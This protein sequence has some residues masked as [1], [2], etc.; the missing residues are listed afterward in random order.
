MMF[1]QEAIKKRIPFLK[2]QKYGQKQNSSQNV[3]EIQN[4]Q[5]QYQNQ[6]NSSKKE[7]K[8]QPFEKAKQQ[9]EKFK[10]RLQKEKDLNSQIQQIVNQQKQKLEND[11]IYQQYIE[12]ETEKDNR[13]HKT[14]EFAPSLITV[15][16]Q[17]MLEKNFLD[18]KKLNSIYRPCYQN[19]SLFACLTSI[20]NYFFT[21]LGPNNEQFDV[22][23]EDEI[24]QFF[25]ITE[26]QLSSSKN[27]IQL[28]ETEIIKKFEEFCQKKTQKNILK[29]QVLWK[30]R[31]ENQKLEKSVE[32]RKTI[33]KTLQN[34][35]NQFI[36]T[37]ISGIYMLI[38]G[39]VITPHR[40][41]DVYKSLEQINEN[42]TYFSVIL[43]DCDSKYKP[44]HTIYWKI[45]CEDFARLDGIQRNPRTNKFL[46]T[47]QDIKNLPEL[48]NAKN[49]N[50]MLIFKIN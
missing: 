13:H 15:T 50:F 6:K 20:Y 41:V 45:I 28:Q 8:K 17:Q 19:S 12:P 36:L 9:I 30:L 7:N 18:K 1:N 29:G 23:D 22:I 32:I 38:V 42:D 5:Q 11:I 26:E 35:N 21:F 46:V 14:N 34:D 43:A 3:D 16:K 39:Y 25:N 44:I 31:G 48:E 4:Y 10:T 24:M 37:K 47:E 49:D 27:E 33:L 2:I 40:Q